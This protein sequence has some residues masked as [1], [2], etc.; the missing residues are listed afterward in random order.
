MI[1]SKERVKIFQDNYESI[2]ENIN[3]LIVLV[4]QKGEVKYINHKPLLKSLGYM[5]DDII[6]KSFLD[7]VNYENLETVINVLKICNE[8]EPITQEIRLKHRKGYF[9]TFE[10]KFSIPIGYYEKNRVLLVLN[11]IIYGLK[12]KEADDQNEEF[13]E[14]YSLMI[15]NANDI[16]ALYNDKLDLEYA[17]ESVIEKLLGYSFEDIKGKNS[18]KIIH[19]EDM[20]RALEN[21]KRVFQYGEAIGE[22]RVKSKKGDYRWLESKGKVFMENGEKKLIMISRDI[23]EK[24]EAEQKLQESVKNYRLLTENINDMV[25]VVNREAHIEYINEETHSKFTGYSVKELLNKS[26]VGLIHP[27]DQNRVILAFNE[28]FKSGEG[29][30][31]ARILHKN[32]YYIWTETRGKTFLDNDGKYK[33]LTVSRDITERKLAEEKLKESEDRFRSVFQSIPDIF[34]LLAEDTTILEYSAKEEDL[35]IPSEEFLG[36]RMSEILPSDLGDLSLKY[37][38]MTLKT[39]MTQILEYTLPINEVIHHYEAR[40]LYFSSNTV[41]VFIGDISNRKNAEFRIKE[42]EERLKHLLSTSPAVIYTAKAS[43]GFEITYLSENVKE[44]TG[45]DPHDFLNNPKFWES[46]I[47]PEDIKSVISRL[48]QIPVLENFGF[49]YRFKFK[50]GLYHWIRHDVRLL[51]DEIGKPSE[52]I[53]SLIDITLNK[54]NE[55]KIQYQAKL[56]DHISDAIISTDLKFNIISWNKAAESIYGWDI[57]EVL[58]RNMK[59]IIPEVHPYDNPQSLLNLLLE[60][61]IWRG[62]AIHSKKDGSNLIVYSSISLIKDITGN[63][64]GAVS[65]NHD[66][67]DIK[68]AEEKIRQSELR[69]R[70]LFENSPVA[71]MEQDF[72]ELKTYID[73]LKTSGINDFERYFKNPEEIL[74]CMIQVKTV[75]V[76][77]KTLEVYKATKKEQVYSRLNQLLDNLEYLSEE[78]LLDN[79]REMLTLIKGETMYESELNLKNFKG[80]DMYV[81]AKTSILPGFED[82]WEKVILS[83]VDITYLKRIQEKLRESELKFRTIAE[84]SALGVVIQQDGFIQ[85]ANTAVAEMIEY[86]LQNIETWSV[87]DTY[88]II[89]KDDVELIIEKFNER[90]EG[91][92]GSVNQYEC[93]IITQSG[94]LKWIDIYTKP[95][96]YEGRE[97]ILITFMDITVKKQI[98]EQLKEVSRLK[99]ELLSRTS[100]ELKTPL[101]SIKGYADLLLNQHYEDLDFY[102]I[103]VL[104][105]IKQGCSRLESLIKDLL[106]TSKLESGQ[107]KLNKLEDDLAFLIRFCVRDLK[108]LVETRN[109]NLILDIKEKMITFF[110]KERI[111]EVIVNLLSNAIKYTPP[112]GKIIIRSEIRKGKYVISVEDTGIGL[113]DEEK[114]KIFKKFGKIERYG[115]GLDVVSEGSGLGLYISKKIVE[116]H[117]GNIWVKSKGRKKGSTF[118]FS[119]PIITS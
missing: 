29:S 12:K 59:D 71:L 74:K 44:W 38:E 19:P 43:K 55:E 106:E 3:E 67:T 15:E 34:F 13:S 114:E 103:S 101:V 72:S 17:N 66:I 91:K 73:N 83:M 92:S 68:K 69:Y 1:E 104:H 119:L 98:E 31:E 26:F 60:K 58:M 96:V 49:E 53:G 90:Q 107:I 50:D 6:G 46:K 75:N 51:R 21:F 112:N 5:A 57:N 89:H 20:Q 108:G 94:K 65:I 105:E 25:S 80:E 115:Q 111:Y 9:K 35:Y 85:F 23:T 48:S 24:K 70:D 63:P 117:G 42:S 37:V 97:A 62:E 7:Y 93:R 52:I 116:L 22:T 95:I 76:N 18:L 40:F 84:Q 102:T 41:A 45:Y 100:H 32:G 118:Y 64:I 16:I 78:V 4:N 56:V 86:P 2:T 14:K 81:Y 30:I 39:K 82:T 110:E 87:E 10:S 47:H 8:K 27:D 61:G 11:E 99:S 28:T 54:K 33:I 79:K 88:K 113:T 77:N 36:K 109:H